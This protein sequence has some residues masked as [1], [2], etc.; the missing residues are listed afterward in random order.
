MSETE[1]PKTKK[2]QPSLMEMMTTEKDRLTKLKGEIEAQ[3]DE[4]NTRLAEIDTDLTR[5]DLFINPPA[6]REPPQKTR[7]PRQSSGQRAPRGERKEA[8]LTAI[9]ENPGKTTGELIDLLGARSDA[10]TAQAVSQTIMNLKKSN[11]IRTEGDGRS[12]KHYIP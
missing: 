10:K 4:L 11:A 2:Q 12:G 9:R 6:I 1:A 5:I 7:K 3:R 8:V